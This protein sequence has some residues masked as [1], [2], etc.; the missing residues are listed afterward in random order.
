MTVEEVD[1]GIVGL[2]T[3]VERMIGVGS[4]VFDVGSLRTASIRCPVRQQLEPQIRLTLTE[5][6]LARP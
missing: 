1:R 4:L 6:C 5:A 3:E 2:G